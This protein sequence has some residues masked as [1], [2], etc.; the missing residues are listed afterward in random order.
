MKIIHIALGIG[1]ILAALATVIVAFMPA[2]FSDEQFEGVSGTVAGLLIVQVVVGF[3]LFTSQVN[4]NFNALIHI[5]PPVISLA[6]V[7]GA[8]ATQGDRRRLLV[9]LAGALVLVAGVTS[10]LT[11]LAARTPGG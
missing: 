5:L 1:I 8:R 3:F 11:G 6:A 10:Y 2:K 9:S 7:F 4:E